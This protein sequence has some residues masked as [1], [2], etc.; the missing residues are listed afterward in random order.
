MKKQL[1]NEIRS[2]KKFASADDLHRQ[3][4]AVCE[5]ILQHPKWQEADTV[6]LYHA[7]PDELDTSLLLQQKGKRILLP[8][9]VGD[10]LELRLFT[11]ELH[12]GS[13]GIME[14]GG[15]KAELGSSSLLCIVPGMAFDRQG[16]R[17]GR[18]KGYYDRLFAKLSDK[19]LYKMGV[20]FDFQ[21]LDAVPS[22][23]HDIVMDE[24]MV[25]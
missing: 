4:Q 5:R 21:L 8:V 24:V 16:H 25:G 2:R 17:L 13:Y 15:V 14:P 11:G 1:R 12:E 7:L 3:S 9:V 19:S 22:E 20:C 6:L 23:P 10:D 18:G